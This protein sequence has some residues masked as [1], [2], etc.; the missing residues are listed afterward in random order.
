EKVEI[1]VCC[2][3]SCRRQGC[4]DILAVLSGIAPPRVSVASCGCLGRC[5]AGPN[6]VILPEGV[7]YGHCGTPRKAA[8]VMSAVADLRVDECLE[9]LALRKRAEDERD[10]GDFGAAC[11]LLTQALDLHPVG[12]IHKIY[13]ERSTIRLRM[14]DVDGALDDARE[15]TALAPEDPEPYICRGDALMAKGELRDSEDCYS[16]ALRLDPSIARS[17]TFKARISKLVEE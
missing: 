12:N 6:L 13:K 4:R 17:R 10:R 11:S 2:N 5:G 7:V 14:G 3:R 16:M 8:E 15:A 1:K 9:A